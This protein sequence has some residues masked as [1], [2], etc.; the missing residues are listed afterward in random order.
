MAADPRERDA[1]AGR[2]G[3]TFYVSSSDH[4][5]S[6]ERD[7]PLKFIHLHHRDR[8]GQRRRQSCCSQFD[9]ARPTPQEY[10]T[11]L[12]LL[13]DIGGDIPSAHIQSRITHLPNMRSLRPRPIA[14]L[15]PLLAFLSPASAVTSP[16]NTG[17]LPQGYLF[18]FTTSSLPLPIVNSCPSSLTVS[19]ATALSYGGNDPS[20]PYYMMF[21]VREQLLD[22]NNNLY[23]RYYTHT[24]TLPDMNNVRSLFNPF[25]NGTQFIACVTSANGVSGGCQVSGL[26]HDY[27]RAQRGGSK[28]TS[29]I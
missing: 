21:M 17:D 10:R 8:E 20:S 28:L 19:T 6:F 2:L 18:G 25:M 23:E 5:L 14:I 26:I 15:L 11:T 3:S 9:R 16:N 29:R 13:P 24:E 27:T 4:F 22:D 7:Y 12:P 1:Q